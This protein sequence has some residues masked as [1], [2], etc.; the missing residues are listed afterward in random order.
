LAI[1]DRRAAT[2]GVRVDVVGMQL[3]GL[4]APAEKQ[5]VSLA[6]R[7]GTGKNCRTIPATEST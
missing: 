1:R 4:V 7:A 3:L 6:P 2:L 5:T